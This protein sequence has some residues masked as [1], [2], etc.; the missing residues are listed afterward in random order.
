MGGEPVYECECGACDE[1][2]GRGMLAVESSGLV[3]LSLTPQNHCK[4]MEYFLT[5]TA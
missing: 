3:G 1:Q 2:C 5:N 4:E